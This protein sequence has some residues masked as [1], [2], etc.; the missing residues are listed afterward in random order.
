MTQGLVSIVDRD[1]RTLRK[2]VVGDNG[3]NAGA[4]ADAIRTK[5]RPLS[6]RQLYRLALDHDFGCPDCLIV[7]GPSDEAFDRASI[8]EVPPSY[9]E[10]F[11]EPRWN[12]RW[13]RGTCAHTEIVAVT[14][15]EEPR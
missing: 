13:A 6:V 3:M 4:V 9:R 5:R 15:P 1:G 12:P 8:E 11:A 10:H 14:W 7:Q 2:I